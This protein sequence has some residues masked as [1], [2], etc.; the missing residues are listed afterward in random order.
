[1]HANTGSADP[2]YTFNA[3]PPKGNQVL[4]CN[5]ILTFWFSDYFHIAYLPIEA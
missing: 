2:L 5:P 4:N 3:K 1:M